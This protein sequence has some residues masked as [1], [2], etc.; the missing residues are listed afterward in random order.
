MTSVP[1]VRSTAAFIV[2]AAALMIAKPQPARSTEPSSTAPTIS[3][4]RDVAPIIF[5]KCSSCHHAGEAAPF[6]LLTYDDVRRHAR[7]IAEVTQK[8]LMPPWLP[9]E[10]PEVFEG[11]RRLG[12]GEL[13][14]LQQWSDAG[15]P[16]GNE[17]EMPAPPRFTEGW[18]LGT[19]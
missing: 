1:G 10:G 7:Q 3:F 2:L 16:R 18:Q 17:S 6:S 14:I 12:D 5:T 8:R 9:S 13:K 15:A 19:P 11:A 4:T